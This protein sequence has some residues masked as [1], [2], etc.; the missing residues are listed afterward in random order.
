MVVVAVDASNQKARTVKVIQKTGVTFGVLL[1]NKKVAREVYK[2]RGTPT[3]FMIDRDGMI[4]FKH[5]GY[6]P[7][8]ETTMESEVQSLV[9]GPA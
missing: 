6:Y 4:V 7:G 5:V 3:T 8:L 9:G 2:V 1:D